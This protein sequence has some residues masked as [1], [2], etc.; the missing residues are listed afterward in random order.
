MK[1]HY[2]EA[3]IIEVLIGLDHNG[4]M[5]IGDLAINLISLIPLV[6][7]GAKGAKILSGHQ[8]QYLQ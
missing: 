3:E 4:Q 5:S 2:L 6:G 8:K 1:D 7:W